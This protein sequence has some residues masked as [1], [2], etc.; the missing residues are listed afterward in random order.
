MTA[1]NIYLQQSR[2]ILMTDA[3]FI[4]MA[5]TGRP[6]GFSEKCVAVPGQRMAVAARGDER[7]PKGVAFDIALLYEGIDSLIADE[8]QGV[9]DSYQTFLRSGL[10]VTVADVD[11][12]IVGW[13]D[14][15]DRPRGCYLAYRANGWSFDE[16]DHADG[17]GYP[18][19]PDIEFDRLAAA[20]L[21]PEIH[22]NNST[23]DP[24]YHGVPLMEAQRRTPA[25]LPSANGKPVFSIGGHILLTEVTR[26]GVTQT[27][28]HEWPDK[29]GVPIR[30]APYG[31]TPKDAAALD[32]ATEK[33]ARKAAKLQRIAS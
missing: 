10:G 4:D 30:P 3:L 19:L 31:A 11:V 21:S 33:R 18:D 26:D 9:R 14:I 29:W 5:D 22:Y 8:G 7:V 1:I 28:I 2:G 27:V 16:F 20:G 12:M 32:A 25:P 24:I 23:F 13:S 6:V 17:F 15:E